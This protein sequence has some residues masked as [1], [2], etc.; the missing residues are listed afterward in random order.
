MAIDQEA[1]LREI[2][3]GPAGGD[4]PAA[5]GAVGVQPRHSDVPL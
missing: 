3:S 5:A 4:Q 1:I 2:F